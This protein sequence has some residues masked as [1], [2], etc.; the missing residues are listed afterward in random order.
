[1][2]KVKILFVAVVI[3]LSFAVS[4]CT[5]EVILPTGEDGSST[6]NNDPDA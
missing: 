4:S 3:G 2:K 5:E 6:E 1:M